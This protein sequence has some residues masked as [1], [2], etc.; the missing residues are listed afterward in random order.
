M[1]ATLS[2]RRWI[3]TRAALRVLLSAAVALAS[4]PSG[5][6]APPLDP[7]I[8]KGIKQVDDG[9]YDAAILTLDGAARR[10][11]ADPKRG[12]ELSQAYLYLGIAYVGKGQEAAARARFREALGQIKDLSLSP[13]RYP[14]KVIDV[15]EAA[16][17]DMAKT[18]P[19]AKPAPPPEKKG[20]GGKTLLIIGGVA[21]VGA[22]V[23][24]AAGGGGESGPPATT[25]P[26]T[27]TFGPITLS[28]A[29]CCRNFGIFVARAGTLNATV[30]WTNAAV[31]FAMSLDDPDNNFNTVATSNQTGNLEARLQGQVTNLANGN[32]KRYDLNVYFDD[33]NGAAQSDS[34]TLRVTH[35]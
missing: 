17:E 34:F 19:A 6:Q 13:D 1:L 32:P 10:L 20:G 22:G 14:P 24:V 30:T 16:K 26:T 11:A 8:Q 15:F 29:E 25:G 2:P 23:A 31:Q 35:P 9:D 18:P 5:A 7:E 33:H 4:V 3:V 27:D 28:I 21:A 12:R